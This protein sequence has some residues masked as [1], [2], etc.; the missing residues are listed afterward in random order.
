MH[1]Y[2]SS[3]LD[4]LIIY[5]TK[6]SNNSRSTYYTAVTKLKNLITTEQFQLFEANLIK[7]LQKEK[8]TF[9]KTNESK[10]IRDRTKIK[11]KYKEMADTKL[12]SHICKRAKKKVDRKNRRLLKKNY[13]SRTRK[14]SR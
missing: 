4:L 7:K 5:Y 6:W 2:V 8:A 12:P 10:L 14:K 3:I 13:L 9:A 1:F 11:V